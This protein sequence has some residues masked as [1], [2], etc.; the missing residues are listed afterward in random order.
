MKQKTA[1]MQAGLPLAFVLIVAGCSTGVNGGAV[2]REFR[3]TYT[4]S[5]TGS[6][7]EVSSS[8]AAFTEMTLGADFWTI[9]GATTPGISTRNGG[10][11][12]VTYGTTSVSCTWAYVYRD[13]TKIGLVYANSAGG[14]L[15]LGR[16]TAGAVIGLTL[17]ATIGSSQPPNFEATG[18]PPYPHFTGEK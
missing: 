8:G 7:G 18:I 14:T 12:N 1:L 6:P 9:N 10:T 16:D 17:I 13:E 3:G 4:V 11:F 5:S 2:A 15:A